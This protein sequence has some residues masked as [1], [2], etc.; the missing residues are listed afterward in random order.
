MILRFQAAKAPGTMFPNPVSFDFPEEDFL[1]VYGPFDESW[2]VTRPELRGNTIRLV[3]SG[4]AAQVECNTIT[5]F[6]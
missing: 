3:Y 2:A 5:P 1:G 6:N 4:V